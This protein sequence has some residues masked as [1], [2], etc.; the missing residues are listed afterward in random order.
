MD[1]ET[2]TQWV[3]SAADL[4]TKDTIFNA[5]KAGGIPSTKN[6]YFDINETYISVLVNV[7]GKSVLPDLMNQEIKCQWMS[8]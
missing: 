4:I 6:N 3:K 5:L 2:M 1:L 8:F 7:L